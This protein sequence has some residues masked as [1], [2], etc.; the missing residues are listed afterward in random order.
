MDVQPDVHTCWAT[1]YSSTS[2]T[3]PPLPPSLD[4]RMYHDGPSKNYTIVASHVVRSNR[5]RLRFQS[6]SHS[7]IDGHRFPRPTTSSPNLPVPIMAYLFMLLH[8]NLDTSMSLLLAQ[9]SS[10]RRMDRISLFGIFQDELCKSSRLLDSANDHQQVA[11]SN[12]GVEPRRQWFKKKVILW[13]R[14]MLPRDFIRMPLPRTDRHTYSLILCTT[15]RYTSE[16]PPENDPSMSNNCLRDVGLLEVF[17]LL[18][19]E[20]DVDCLC[21]E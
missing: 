6:L 11:G 16:A 7:H 13:V 4:P 9:D 15:L 1:L 5:E 8:S 12:S 10:Y 14:Y 18:F 3:Y 20:L 21:R 17:D 19:S 2:A